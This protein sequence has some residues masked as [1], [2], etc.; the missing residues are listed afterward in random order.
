V[1]GG[2][3]TVT[4]MLGMIKIFTMGSP[5]SPVWADIASM[6]VPQGWAVRGLSQVMA[7]AAPGDI[8]LTCLVLLGMSVVF[9]LI[10]VLRFQKRYA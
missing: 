2:L 9:F 7:A 10:G 3:L 1:L 5:T 6:F 8:L 4:G